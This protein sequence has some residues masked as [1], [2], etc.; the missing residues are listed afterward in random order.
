MQ[1]KFISIS[2]LP[3]LISCAFGFTAPLSY[4]TA[5]GVATASLD[6]VACS[7]GSH[8]LKTCGFTT[9]GSLPTFPYIGGTE[10][11]AGWNSPNCGTCYRLTYSNKTSGVKKSVNVLAVDRTVPGFNV[12]LEAMQVLLGP[13]AADIGT[14]VVDAVQVDAV[15]CGLH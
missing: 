12:A 10:A 11:I 7:D 3:L 8:G 1:P 14:A 6:T 4:D 2:L 9:F 15:V 13:G 5:Y